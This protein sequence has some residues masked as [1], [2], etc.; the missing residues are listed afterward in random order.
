LPVPQMKKRKH[1]VVY[2]LSV[3]VSMLFMSFEQTQRFYFC[4]VTY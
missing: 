1:S 4:R 2:A 3:S